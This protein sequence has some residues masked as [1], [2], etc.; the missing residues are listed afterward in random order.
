MFADLCAVDRRSA[1]GGLN[2]RAHQP[3]TINDRGK[4][5]FFRKAGDQE[6]SECAD[7]TLYLPECRTGLTS[8]CATYSS[9]SVKEPGRPSQGDA[10]NWGIAASIAISALTL[11]RSR[12][13]CMPA[14][15]QGVRSSI[16]QQVAKIL[17]PSDERNLE[18]RIQ[19]ALVAI[20]LEWRLRKG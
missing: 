4:P 12:S 5:R 3:L 19:E 6:C 17:F 1:L 11:P 9:I 16:T 18:V 15:A 7:P 8:A 14:R 2:I 13:H 10:G 20:W